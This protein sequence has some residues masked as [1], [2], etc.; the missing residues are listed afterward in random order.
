[1]L[2]CC[3]CSMCLSIL[4][5]LHGLDYQQP[6]PALQICAGCLHAGTG[7]R[8][9]CSECRGCAAHADRGCGRALPCCD[10]RCL[11]IKGFRAPWWVPPVPAQP[12][13]LRATPSRPPTHRPLG[14]LLCSEPL[15]RKRCVSCV[16]KYYLGFQSAAAGT[17]HACLVIAPRSAR[18]QQPASCY[19]RC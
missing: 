2:L 17:P 10:V 18:L 19:A 4:C 9:R 3:R 15:A 16:A 11:I 8:Q 1:M 7:F 12:N 5:C 14:L 6:Q 13:E